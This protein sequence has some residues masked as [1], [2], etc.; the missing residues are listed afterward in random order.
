M[1]IKSILTTALVAS[2]GVSAFATTDKTITG[3]AGA[4]GTRVAI[5]KGDYNIILASPATTTDAGTMFKGATSTITSLDGVTN[6]PPVKWNFTG[7]LNIDV[8]SS[9]EGSVKA[10]DFGENKVQ[11]NL[12]TLNIKNSSAT[13]ETF[14][15]VNIG[16]ELRFTVNNN[17]TESSILGIRTNANIT[18]T[19]LA[20]ADM[21]NGYYVVEG[22][23]VNHSVKNTYLG[24]GV[25]LWVK[26]GATFNASSD[27]S[28]RFYGGSKFTISDGATAQAYK[29]TADATS[30]MSIEGAY[31]HMG[32]A[33]STGVLTIEGGSLV[34]E[35][36]S[37]N[38]NARITIKGAGSNIYSGGTISINGALEVSQADFTVDSTSGLITLKDF[39]DQYVGRAILSTGKLTINKESAFKR[40]TT[41]GNETNIKL[42]YHGA[43]N[44]LVIN[45]TT[46]FEQIY[47][48]DT[49]AELKITLSSNENVKLL[50]T[51]GLPLNTAGNTAS[52][53]FSGL[54]IGDERV[55]FVSGKDELT[56]SSKFTL[57]SDKGY[58]FNFVKGTYDGK[59]GFWMVAVPEPAEWAVIFGAIALGLAIYRRRK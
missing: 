52:I 56:L 38:T 9:V 26:T 28:L 31:T 37:G 20:L 7:T 46:A 41:S 55:F 4:S 21:Y 30:T 8:N 22:G 6:T 10:L 34:A 48:Y 23:T 36:L 51:G 25:T 16:K 12:G 42:L 18:G 2:L 39:N 50:I 32:S 49:V 58:D 57:L 19:S 35:N 3:G 24:A 59:A 33:L 44:E 5:E 40:I 13:D 29:V 45:A 14:L 15:D 43:G 27:A 47:A 53:T 54:G 11:W 1:N 17:K